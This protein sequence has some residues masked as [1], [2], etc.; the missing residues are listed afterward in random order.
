[1]KLVEKNITARRIITDQSIEN[2]V[3][4]TSAIGGSTNAALH[5]PAIAYE[6]ELKFDL[7]M[8][9]RLSRSTPLIA[10]MNPAASYNVIDF[11]EA[12]GVQ[13]VMGE[14]KSL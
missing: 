4:L 12:G 6:A 3:R 5:V 13:A 14:L 2:A 8:F 9:D 11:Y 10:K 1:M 7:N